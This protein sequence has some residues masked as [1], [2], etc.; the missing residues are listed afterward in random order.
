MWQRQILSTERGRL[1]VLRQTRKKLQEQSHRGFLL[2]HV[3]SVFWTTHQILTSIWI[4]II[5]R[6]YR[7]WAGSIIFPWFIIPSWNRAVVHIVEPSTL[8]K[9]IMNEGKWKKK[10]IEVLLQYLWRKFRISFIVAST[11]SIFGVRMS[12]PWNVSHGFRFRTQR[13]GWSRPSAGNRTCQFGPTPLGRL[14]LSTVHANTLSSSLESMDT[15]LYQHSGPAGKGSYFVTMETICQD[16]I[17]INSLGKAW[18]NL[19]W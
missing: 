6:P 4:K 13:H 1:S 5:S 10:I 2:S 9:Q 11:L 3:D 17:C 8:S 18:F 15:C 19:A 7:G 12:W 14:P 16:N